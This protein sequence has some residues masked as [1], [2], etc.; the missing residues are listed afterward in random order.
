LHAAC[1]PACLPSGLV[2]LVFIILAATNFRLILE[3]MMK[4][5]FRFNPLTFLRNAVTPSG[6]LPLLLCWPLLALF[7][8]CALGIERFA[9]RLLAMEQWEAAASRKREVGYSEMKRRAA[10]R[11]SAT[12]ARQGWG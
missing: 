5:G 2:T 4:Y 12:G 7:A 9:A 10:R 6:N 3:N 11:A 1:L 8:L